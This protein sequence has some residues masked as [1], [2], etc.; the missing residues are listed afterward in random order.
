[1][2]QQQQQQK[3]QQQLQQMFNPT[4]AA[5]L[6]NQ[7][8]NAPS[9]QAILRSNSNNNSNNNNSNNNTNSYV[10]PVNMKLMNTSISPNSPTHAGS[11]VNQQ[12]QQLQS[13]GNSNEGIK[14]PQINNQSQFIQSNPASYY[15]PNIILKQNA[16]KSR[17]E[18]E[19]DLL[20]DLLIKNLNSS[21]LNSPSRTP[22]N[23]GLYGICVRC[24]EKVIGVDNGIS[25]MDNLF[26]VPCFS[27]F[28]CGFSLQNQHFYAMDNNPYCE[29]CYIV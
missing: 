21:N 12:Q 14:Q 4:I 28:S 5:F 18:D 29:E 27:C 8:A 19:V 20:K 6:A 15:Q 16:S 9:N 17:I 13:T 11:M 26:H 10:I 3:H 2:Q 24:N 25:A 1:M 7:I 23:D 22:V